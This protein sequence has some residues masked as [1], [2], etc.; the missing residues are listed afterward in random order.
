MELRFTKRPHHRYDLVV[1]GRQGPEVALRDHDAGPRLPH[2]LVHAAVERTLGIDDGF[3]AALAA[4]ATF[5][6][7]VPTDPT[8]RHRRSGLKVLRR[9][10]GAVLAAELRVNFAYRCWSGRATP[11]RP[12][13]TDDEVR[14]AGDAIEEAARR[15]AA[16]AEGDTLVVDW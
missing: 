6:G 4:G 7:F 2:D 13:L 10:G 8:A 16:T 12:V 5:D 14:R 3:C 15:W 9:Q 11:G 1:A